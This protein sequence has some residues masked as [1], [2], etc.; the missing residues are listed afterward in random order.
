M[1]Y[2]NLIFKY[3]LIF[4]IWI[5]PNFTLADPWQIDQDENFITLKK[6]GE[7]QHGNKIHFN[8]DKNN[9]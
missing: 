1:Y 9:G 6:N 4:S 5:T 3:I 2:L 7:I 8:F